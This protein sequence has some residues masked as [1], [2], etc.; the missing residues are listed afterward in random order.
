[1]RS[2]AEDF[3]RVEGLERAGL[4]FVPEP[5]G[6]AGRGAAGAAAALV[7]GGARDAAGFERGEAGAGIVGRHAAEAG[8]DDDADA[9]DGERGFGDRG[10][11]HDLAAAGGRRGDGAILLV[12][13]E[14]AVE[15]GDIDVGWNA[16]LQALGGAGDLG[17]AGEEDEDR[18]VVGAQRGEDGGGDLILE[19]LQRIGRR[20]SGSRPGRPGPRF[21][22]PAHRRAASRRGRRRWWP[23]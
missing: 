19:A 1:M 2:A 9:L 5:I 12:G 17:L 13:G 3:G 14:L 15:R 7:G 4:A 10:R 6:D 22:S 8:I 21:R 16:V 20:R 18:A 23:T 11:E